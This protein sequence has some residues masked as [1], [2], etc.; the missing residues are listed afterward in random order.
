MSPTD[1]VLCGQTKIM[2]NDKAKMCQ[3]SSATDCVDCQEDINV[4]LDGKIPPGH[5]Y[6]CHHHGKV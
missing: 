2:V 6:K 4:R 3:C 1:C 5:Q